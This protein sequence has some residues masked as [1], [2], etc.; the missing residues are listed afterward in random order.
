MDFPENVSPSV[1]LERIDSLDLESL[2][3]DKAAEKASDYVNELKAVLQQ[4]QPD[5]AELAGYANAIL[6]WYFDQGSRADPAQAQLSALALDLARPA[7]RFALHPLVT[8]VIPGMASRDQVAENVAALA[9]P[10]PPSAGEL[11]ALRESVANLGERFCRR[12]QYCLPCPQG[13]N[14]PQVFICA[15]TATW[16]GEPE[17]ARSM[18]ERLMTPASDCTECGECEERCPYLI[19]I[20]EMLAEAVELL[21]KQL[22]R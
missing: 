20:R 14:I 7:L 3:K 9:D 15:T 12:C 19:P 5:L 21:E 16:R 22:G 2:H 1:L 13:I 6:H 18:Y 17:R 8:T 11:Q 10:G 4:E